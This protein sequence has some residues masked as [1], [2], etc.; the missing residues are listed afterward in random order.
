MAII[1][2]HPANVSSLFGNEL[3]TVIFLI[4]FLFL[5][6][7]RRLPR[8]GLAVKL[9]CLFW[10]QRLAKRLTIRLE[11]LSLEQPPSVFDNVCVLACRNAVLVSVSSQPAKAVV[12]LSD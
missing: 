6:R 7:L 11:T 12:T 1:D 10:F 5:L 4:P 3:V 9:L 8:I 2:T